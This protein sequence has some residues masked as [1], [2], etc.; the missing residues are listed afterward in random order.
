MEI[1]FDEIRYRTRR[2]KRWQRGMVRWCCDE[3]SRK[4]GF[5]E[6]AV[7]YQNMLFNELIG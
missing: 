6:A 1:V 3:R 5:F 2:A 4:Y 7:Q